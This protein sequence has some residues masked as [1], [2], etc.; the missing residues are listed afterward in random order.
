MFTSD[1][2]ESRS[3]EGR[4]NDITK[5]AFQEFLRFLYTE[6][7]EDIDLYVL[8]LLAIADLYEV[9]DLKAICKAQLLTGL[10][11]ENSTH[12]FQYAHRYRCDSE[13]KEAAFKL[14]KSSFQKHNIDIP[15]EFLFAPSALQTAI[16][17][18]NK[19]HETLMV[20]VALTEMRKK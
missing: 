8:E 4:I 14:I 17:A 16:D 3:N 9:E 15:N 12:V 11:E 18:K 13:L 19:I 2:N 10:T 5:E 6:T 7:I 1:F 20:D